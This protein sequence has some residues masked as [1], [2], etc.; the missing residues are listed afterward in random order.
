MFRWM[1][2]LAAVTAPPVAHAQDY[3]GWPQKDFGTWHVYRSITGCW[4][5]NDN[6]PNDFSGR[7]SLSTSAE[8]SDLYI[9]LEA[10]DWAWQGE[11]S[12]TLAVRFGAVSLSDEV[13]DIES[14]GT[15]YSV[16]FDA[17][18]DSYL[19]ALRQAPNLHLEIAAG[20]AIDV[21]LTSSHEAFAYFEQCTLK[22]RSEKK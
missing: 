15:D 7:L 9:D 6:L 2:A 10:F 16:L 3:P 18:A 17:P 8:K 22:L 21:P 13:L 19:G 1:L 20:R 14:E 4:I 5:V 11:G 12:P